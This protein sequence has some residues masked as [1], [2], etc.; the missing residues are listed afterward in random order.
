MAQAK[1]K[2][3]G[4]HK[5]RKEELQAKTRDELRAIAKEMEISGRGSMTKAQ[6]V[7]AIANSANGS[8]EDGS[9]NENEKAE[10]QVVKD[11][12]NADTKM[13]GNSKRM[14]YVETVEPGTIMAFRLPDGKVKSAKLV[15]RS[16]KR[17]MLLLVTSYGKEFKVPFEDVVWVKTGTRWPCG[18]YKLLKG[19][20]VASGESKEA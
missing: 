15:K 18:V 1:I 12:C 5:M 2:R 13:D 10:E 14:T 6:L 4:V 16:T 11:T 3:K 20:G 17:R 9:K 7:E 19:E 8:A